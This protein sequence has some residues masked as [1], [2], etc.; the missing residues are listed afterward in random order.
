LVVV[1]LNFEEFKVKKALRNTKKQK[2]PTAIT[3]KLRDVGGSLVSNK[4][5]NKISSDGLPGKVYRWP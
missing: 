3:E 1:G 2:L 4:N 5:I